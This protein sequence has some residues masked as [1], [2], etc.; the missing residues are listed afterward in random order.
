[1]LYN[2]G[3]LGEKLA[4]AHARLHEMITV[5]GMS[6]IFLM[7]TAKGLQPGQEYLVEPLKG[8]SN[9]NELNLY[10]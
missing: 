1:M 7:C 5:S 6:E 3:M 10:E 9:K 2:Y 8:K 4:I